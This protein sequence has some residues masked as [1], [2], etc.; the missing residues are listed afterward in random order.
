MSKTSSA[1][2]SRWNA[3]AYDQ[4]IV[5]V[6]KGDKDSIKAFAEQNGESLN[7]YISRLIEE[8]MNKKR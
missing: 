2:K 3:K 1:V 7:G 8:D 6:K 4:I 5:R